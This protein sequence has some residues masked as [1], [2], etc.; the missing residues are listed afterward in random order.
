M[1]GAGKTI[2]V[3]GGYGATGLT[4]V[5]YLLQQTGVRLVLA[6]RR[7][8]RADEVTAQLNAQFAGERVSGARADAADGESLAAAFRDVDMVLVCSPTTEHVGQV[9]RAALAAGIDYMDIHFPRK[10]IPVMTA[11]A[12]AIEQAGRCFIYQAGFHPGLPAVFVRHAAAQFT[13]LRSATVG[14][15]MCMKATSSPDSAIELV[16][17]IGNPQAEVLRNGIWRPAGYKDMR[18]IDFGP[19]FGRRDCY[20]SMMEEMRVL[21]RLLGLE[22]AGVYLAGFNW[23][24]DWLVI[25]LIMLAW[26]IRPGLAARSLSRLMMWG[27]NTFSRPP[28]GVVFKLEAE[29]GHEGKTRRVTTVARHENGYDL[30]AIPAVACLLQYLDGS[31]ARPGLHM[32]GQVVDPARLFTDMERM[33]VRIQTR[34]LDG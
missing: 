24:V 15:A 12:P 27:W 22:E 34:V 21:P 2:V 6:G 11:L 19:G 29:G 28:Y 31:I 23:F 16:E 26:K 10:V 18:K 20:P 30:T 33:G 9:A 5:R 14:I 7:K 4:V 17:D 1:A 3:L 25:P 32:M 8:E 13:R